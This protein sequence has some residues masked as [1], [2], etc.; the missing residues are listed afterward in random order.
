MV[1][2]RSAKPLY[3]GSNPAATSISFF[4]I[5]RLLMNSDILIRYGEISLKGR[6]RSSFENTLINNI[7]KSIK[8]IF[9][10]KVIKTYGRLYIND[11]LPSDEENIISRLTK[12]PGIVSISAV[13]KT[14]IN[15]DDIKELSLKVI[16]EA[17][18]NNKTFRVV[19]KRANKSFPLPSPEVSAEVGGYIWTNYNGELKVDLHNP[20]LVLYIEI[21]EKYA[22]IY[23][24]KIFGIGGLPVGSGGKGLLLLSGG[25]DSPVAGWLGMKRG[26]VID[27]IHF[28]SFPFTGEKSKEKVIELCKILKNYSG[29]INLIIA[30]FTDIQKAISLNC[31]ERYHITI[32]RRMMLRLA[33]RFARKRYCKVLFTGENLAQV[34]SQTVESLNVINAVTNI[35]VLR[36]LI[37]M[38]KNEIIAFARKIGTYETSI[39]PYDDCCTVFVPKNP[40]I[41]PTIFDAEDYEKDLNINSLLEK[42]INKSEI[43]TI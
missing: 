4:Q 9:P 14:N 18:K 25:I 20:D 40:V 32:M 29:E 22:Y 43:I 8:N 5:N 30:Y 19:T 21:R 31:P 6:N 11:V 26:V 42:A 13:K 34:A 35:P 12:I 37:T 17:I 33:E 41:K 39:L 15:L 3:A 10:Y 28:Y 38:D 27:C 24:E 1:R 7:K 16:Q 36:P 23:S 2:R